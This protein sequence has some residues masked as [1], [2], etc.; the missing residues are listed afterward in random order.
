MVDSTYNGMELFVAIICNPALGG[1]LIATS[2]LKGF[3]IEHVLLSDERTNRLN[4][5]IKDVR[6]LTKEFLVAFTISSI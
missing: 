4:Q 5:F 3:T 2:R 1:H 6:C